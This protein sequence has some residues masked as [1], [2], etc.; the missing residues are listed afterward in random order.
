MSIDAVRWALQLAPPAPSPRESLVLVYLAERAD[1]HGHNAFPSKSTIAQHLFGEFLP[2][3]NADSTE[4]ERKAYHRDKEAKERKVQNALARLRKSGHISEDRDCKNPVWLSIPEHSKP[5]P[6]RLNMSMVRAGSN[7]YPGMELSSLT[8]GDKNVPRGQKHP[9][10]GDKYVYTAGSNISPKP[11]GE[12]PGEP[13]GIVNSSAGMSPSPLQLP[14]TI[15]SEIPEDWLDISDG[16]QRCIRRHPSGNRDREA[17]GGCRDTEIQ[18]KKLRQQ[19]DRNKAIQE[20]A[21]RITQSVGTATCDIC[22]HQGRRLAINPTTRLTRD[23]KCGHAELDRIELI[24]A[25][26]AEGKNAEAAKHKG[27]CLRVA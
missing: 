11:S 25:L 3:P 26:E 14:P 6:Y 24:E 18:I 8:R 9:W 16:L 19:R 1:S 10:R 23:V 7:M 13:G 5:T 17:C 2:M 4:G 20:R 12:P 22:N 15:T 21:A 27:K